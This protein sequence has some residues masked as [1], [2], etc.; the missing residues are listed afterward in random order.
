MPANIPELVE[1]T[2]ANPDPL[3]RGGRPLVIDVNELLI[4]APG[5]AAGSRSE[6]ANP[7]RAVARY[8]AG[9][10]R[11]GGS[12]RHNPNSSR[13]DPSQA[14]FNSD[15]MTFLL[16]VMSEGRAI[17]LSS[18]THGE[19]LVNSIAQHLGV[20]SAWSATSRNKHPTEEPAELP[21]ALRQGFDYSGDRA[22][23]LPEFVSRVD[24]PRA[25]DNA[26]GATVGVQTWL[27][28]LRIHQYAKNALV[29]VP[30][31]TAHKFAFAPAVTAL[32]AAIAFSLCASAA[33]ILNDILDVRADRAHPSKRHRPIAC[34][35]ISTA[36]ASYAM[37]LM[38]I[39]ATAIATSISLAFAGV[40]LGYFILTTAYSFWLKRIAIVDV[41]TLA[42]LYSIRV[43]GGA[44]AIDVVVSEWLLAFSL[45]IF[46]SLSLVK[47]HVELDR[48]PDG[49]LLAARGY[50]TSDKPM[51]AILA[52]AA[53]FNAVVIFALYISSESVRSLYSH[54]QL[55]WIG[56]PIL[57]YWIGR[58]LLLAQRGLIDDDPVVF[59]LGDRASWLALG[60]LG[61][62]MLGAM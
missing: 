14:L 28:L 13:F 4:R 50:Q 12:Q 61:L 56:C 2:A 36:Q 30:L 34:G 25:A 52:A 49:N 43:I 47:R 5:F 55:L 15:A 41:I 35:A 44:V 9:L 57:M 3:A 16:Q 24:L 20:S 38:L 51:V 22:L 18:E 27:K 54:P 6:S 62:I 59:A 7:L 17:Y 39:A 37:V 19:P 58:V 40:L 26:T 11:A 21:L 60:A 53:G 23:E 32:I 45:F 42:T 48:Q 46:M 8:V 31:A 1:R 10:F 33:Y 29:L